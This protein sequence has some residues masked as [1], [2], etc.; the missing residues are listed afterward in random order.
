MEEIAYS[1]GFKK[2]N[3]YHIL[4]NIK[5]YLEKFF[6]FNWKKVDTNVAVQV[7][8]LSTWETEQL[9]QVFK[10]SLAYRMRSDQ[11]QGKEKRERRREGTRERGRKLFCFFYT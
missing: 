1:H 11:K 6:F 4:C 8:N 10:I 3:I 7:S 5:S 9:K 2:I